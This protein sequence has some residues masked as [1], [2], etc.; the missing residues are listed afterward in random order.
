[1]GPLAGFLQKWGRAGLASLLPLLAAAL[2]VVTWQQPPPTVVVAAPNVFSG[3]ANGGCYLATATT[4]QVHVDDW[5]PI[6]IAQGERLVAVQL[7]ANG[8]PLYDFRTDVSNPPSGS[9]LPSLAKQDFAIRC[10]ESYVLS[11]RA[12][13]TGDAA[14]VTVGETTVFTCPAAQPPA[15][16]LFDVWL[17]L[18]VE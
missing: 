6:Q 1:M 5:Q 16:E 3:P 7:Q 13:D 4:C 2:F 8:Q 17:P 9:Y 10:G 11:L 18:V 14:L 12:Q 15:V